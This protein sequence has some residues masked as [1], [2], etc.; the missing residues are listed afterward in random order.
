MTRIKAQRTAQ[1]QLLG[2]CLALSAEDLAGV[3]SGGEWFTIEK[4]QT[5]NGF[6]VEIGSDGV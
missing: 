4:R 1:G 3:D 5:T 2:A 6:V